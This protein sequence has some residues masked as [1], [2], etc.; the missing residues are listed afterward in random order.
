MLDETLI[1]I[2][3]CPVT[4]QPLRRMTPEEKSAHTIPDDEDALCTADGTKVY[5]APEGMPLLL[6]AANDEVAGG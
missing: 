6:P 3:R 4:R 5:R 2:L 1:S